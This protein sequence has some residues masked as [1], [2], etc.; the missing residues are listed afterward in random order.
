MTSRCFV[1]R[2]LDVLGWPSTRTYLAVSPNAVDILKISADW[3]VRAC[4][5]I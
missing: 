2:G 1:K 4:D 3:I 5:Y